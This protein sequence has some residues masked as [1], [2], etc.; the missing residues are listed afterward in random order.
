[1]FIDALVA[2]ALDDLEEERVDVE[3]ALR[4]IARVAWEAGW[5]AGDAQG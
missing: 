2:Q 5:R 3:T 4:V 1:M